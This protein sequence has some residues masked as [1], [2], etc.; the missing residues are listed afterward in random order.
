MGINHEGHVVN[1]FTKSGVRSL[2]LEG[3][4]D[5]F[6]KS[7]SIMVIVNLWNYNMIKFWMIEIGQGLFDKGMS[8][9]ISYYI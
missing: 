9:E 1:L 4:R 7:K 8:A 5:T 3:D 6:K 2:I